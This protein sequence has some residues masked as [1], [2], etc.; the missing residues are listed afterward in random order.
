M[1]PVI[2]LPIKS[3]GAKYSLHHLQPSRVYLAGHGD[4]GSTI[5]IRISY[6]SHVY[7]IADQDEAT[8]HQFSD[9]G[10]KQRYF[11]PKRYQHSLNLPKICQAM[12]EKNY[13][14]WISQDRNTRNNMAVADSNP[15]DGLQYVTL[16][17]LTPS[18][19]SQIDVEVIIKSAYEKY[20]N[21]I[22]KLKKLGVRQI[23][24]KCYYDNISIP[25]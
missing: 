15:K 12:I 21:N 17:S 25:K 1:F 13:P 24:K 23:V 22:G 18:H 14:T 8:S 10:G 11:C 3:N 6:Y 7:S 9:E 2:H 19:E 16:Y 5:V 20:I 4:D